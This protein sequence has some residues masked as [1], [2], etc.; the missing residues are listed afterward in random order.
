MIALEIITSVRGIDFPDQTQLQ[1]PKTMF[2]DRIP[3]SALSSTCATG[4]FIHATLQE[5]HYKPS[6]IWT[7]QLH[8]VIALY[9]PCSKLSDIL[10]RDRGTW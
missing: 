7:R 1:V 2:S 10:D 4:A 9:N 5:R 3:L 6:L 8:S